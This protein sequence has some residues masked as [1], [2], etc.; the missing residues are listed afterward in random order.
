[1]ACLVST[2]YVKTEDTKL[3]VHTKGSANCLLILLHEIGGS[4]ESWASVSELLSNHF[5]VVRYDQRGAG[6]SE[7]PKTAITI[8]RHVSDLYRVTIASDENLPIYIAASAGAAPIALQFCRQYTSLL[9]GL[10]LCS[11]SIP[12]TTSDKSAKKA[13]EKRAQKVISEGMVSIVDS[14]MTHMYPESIR[15]KAYTTYRSRFLANDPACFAKLNIAFSSAQVNLDELHLPL[16]YLAGDLDIRP[17]DQAK[18]TAEKLKAADF[19]VVKNTGHVI[20]IQAPKTTATLIENFIIKCL[21][22]KH[23]GNEYHQ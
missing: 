21:K 1:V 20:P 16:L 2:H 13:A 5:K 12:V 18:E 8:D 7:K 3:F 4:S 22:S 19:K 23:K 14:A 17:I 10:I 11:P 9:S 15:G 6:L